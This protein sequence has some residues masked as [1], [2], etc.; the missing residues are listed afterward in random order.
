MVGCGVLLGDM[1]GKPTYRAA[2]GRTAHYG[3]RMHED[4]RDI[5]VISDDGITL[6]ATVHGA[7]PGLPVL[8][9]HGLSQQRHFW[10]PVVRRMRTRPVAA[11]DQRGHGD[12][13]TPLAADFSVGA[14]AADAVACLDALG[15]SEAILVGHS[16]GAAVALAAAAA[17]PDRVRGVA[18]IDGGLWSPSGM[19]TREE[20]LVR[21]TP[22]PL[23]IPEDR[24]WQ[25]IRGGDL[26]PS[27]SDETR[28]ALAPTFAVAADGTARTRIGVARHMRVLEGLLDHAPGAD[29]AACDDAEIPVWA[30]VCEPAG[31]SDE[32]ER[33]DARSAAVRAAAGHAN[34]RIHR[35]AGGIHD[36]PLQWPALVAGFVDALVEAQEVR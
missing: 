12:T 23:G 35:W 34:L 19:G 31:R 27:W 2:A 29:L 36:V 17:R 13:D 30:A 9:L 14:C 5:G 11:L 33:Q 32:D 7:G 22:P 21:L 1:E 4:P 8:L 25:L 3:C 26:G 6:A 10:M 28:A 15:W 18:L 20:V 16:W 24:L